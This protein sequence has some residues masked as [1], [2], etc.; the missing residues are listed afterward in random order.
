V[1]AYLDNLKIALISEEFPPF[2]FGG[3]STLC[4]DLAYSLS[5]KRI[6]TTVFSGKS[7][8]LTIER[9][10]DY[11]EVVRLPV[12]DFPP[13][14][15]WFQLQNYF[16]IS[17]LLEEH[18][19]IHA[20]NPQVSPICIYLKRKLNKPLVTSYHGVPVFELQTFVNT[21]FSCWS[22]GDFAYH[23]LEYPLNEKFIEFSLS[24]SDHIISCS[25]RIL[26]ELMSIYQDLDLRRSSV[27]YNGINFDE[28]KNVG[29]NFTKND[30]ENDFSL[31][32]YGRLYGFKGITYLIE[33]INFLVRDHPN[34]NLKIFG[35]GPIKRR[36]QLL[37]SDLGLKNNI[38]IYDQIPHK[39]LLM[40]I[41]KAD[42]VVLPSL[43]EAQPISVLEAMA[44]RKPIVVF[45]LPF[46]SE[47]IKNYH[48]GLLA[49][50]KDSKDLADKIDILLSD[51]KFRRKMGENAYYYVKRYHNWD[52]L[53]E[54]YIEVYKKVISPN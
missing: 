16:R 12:F 46:V 22:F 51:E 10:N 4:Y 32:F 20:I 25:H 37:V 53:V 35:R 40:E 3:I 8:E 36:I 39:Q 21:P 1:K 11:L 2:T 26:S 54:R 30:N 44:C 9:V 49:K 33:A 28:I 23:I 31:V 47:Y 43:R 41:M 29:D 38:H 48:N 6:F 27:I 15:V 34:L 7:K 5:K 18:T 19:V 24:R 45:N 50:A 52:N 17:R 14:F 13:R 42:V